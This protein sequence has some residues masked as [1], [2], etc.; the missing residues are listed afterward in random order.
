MCSPAGVSRRNKILEKLGLFVCFS[1]YDEAVC[2]DLVSSMR[3]APASLSQIETK[4][5]VLVDETT[6]RSLTVDVPA[7]RE[8]DVVEYFE[9]LKPALESHFD[10]ALRSLERPHFLLYRPGSFFTPH[11]DRQRKATLE[12]SDRQISIVLFLNRD[13]EGGDLTFYELIEGTAWQDKGFPCDAAPGLVV[14]FRSDQLHEVT[15]VISG[16]RFT[17]A[18]WYS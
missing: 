5:S 7:D 2:A 15:P 14:A 9:S 10:V 1:R 3:S 11:R 13:Y 17:I 12:P 16:E 18:S 8:R 4:R 6:R